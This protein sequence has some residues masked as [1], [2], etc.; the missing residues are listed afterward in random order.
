MLIQRRISYVT[1][2]NTLRS[3]WILDLVPTST[4][5]RII[6]ACASRAGITNRQWLKSLNYPIFLIFKQISILKW[7]CF[8]FCGFFWCFVPFWVYCYF[9]LFFVFCCCYF[10]LF[11]FF[12]NRLKVKV[13]FN[14]ISVEFKNKHNIVINLLGLFENTGMR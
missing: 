3:L 1:I 8:F 13:T 12:C 6:R 4:V 5:Y 11:G 7:S 10:C 14:I 2:D 9:Y